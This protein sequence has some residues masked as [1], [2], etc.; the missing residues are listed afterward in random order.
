MVLVFSGFMVVLACFSGSKVII[1]SG[2]SGSVSRSDAM[3]PCFLSCHL[4]F[5]FNLPISYGGFK[6]ANPSS[7]PKG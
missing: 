7:K 1:Y 3:F 6:V 4:L 2:L 5:W